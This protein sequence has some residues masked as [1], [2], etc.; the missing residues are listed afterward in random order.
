MGLR[1][2]SGFARLA[3]LTWAAIESWACGS[4]WPGLMVLVVAAL[5]DTAGACKRV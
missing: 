1:P 3:V 5:L 2:F 4:V